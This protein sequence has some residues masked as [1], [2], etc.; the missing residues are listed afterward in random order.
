MV[1]KWNEP[2]LVKDLTAEVI[3]DSS[4]A[5]VDL[6][7]V[8]TNA[9]DI[10]TLQG[11][12]TTAQTDIT[13]AEA[14]IV[15]LEA[16]PGTA[17]AGSSAESVVSIEQ[18]KVQ[19]VTLTLT[20]LVLN[21][22][23]AN[24]YGSVAFADLPDSNLL[25]LGCEVDLVLTKG[26]ESTGLEA[27]VDLDMAVGT[28][29]ASNT[30]LASTMEDILDKLDVDEDSLTP[31]LQGHSSAATTMPLLIQDGG[32]NKLFLNCGLP[33]G[34]AVDDTLTMT[35]TIVLYYIELGNLTS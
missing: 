11:E 34:I 7:D 20:A 3:R 31:Q 14:D 2:V 9:T 29:A 21:V 30:T 4:G 19:K 26:N 25:F 1:Q 8:G 24:D 17:V 12:M 6:A 33:V 27:T 22:A 5:A 23:A 13:T 10:G 28:V 18:Q 35:G 16:E 15:N 32:T